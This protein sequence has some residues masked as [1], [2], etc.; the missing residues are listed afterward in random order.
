[1]IRVLPTIRFVIPFPSL[2]EWQRQR[3]RYVQAA[4]EPEEAT[5]EPED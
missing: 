2:E 4:T 1:M 3:E 5:N